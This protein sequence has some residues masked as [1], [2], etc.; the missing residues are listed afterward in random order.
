MQL[1]QPGEAASHKKFCVFL[2][3]ALAVSWYAGKL[4][5]DVVY[6]GTLSQTAN[7]IWKI[8]KEQILNARSVPIFADRRPVEHNCSHSVS[9][10]KG[11]A[12]FL[13]LSGVAQVKS[14]EIC[15]QSKVVMGEVKSNIGGGM[16]VAVLDAKSGQPLHT[17]YFNMWDEDN[18]GPLVT[19]LKRAPSRSVILMV[20]S[21]DG[22]TQ[23]SKA[24]RNYIR[25]LGSSQIQQLKSSGNWV[26][27]GTK[28]ISLPKEMIREKITHRQRTNIKYKDWISEI[29]L[30]G[31]FPLKTFKD[32]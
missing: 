1:K 20:M 5:A 12:P 26:F 6:S 31:C 22:S 3:I 8:A 28:G 4:A 30:E 15:F 18:S 9:C 16:N 14:P 11:M 13:L 2:A 23:L 32:I 24:A 10:S 25:L 27:I 17:K 19:F 21:N 29:Y 7:K